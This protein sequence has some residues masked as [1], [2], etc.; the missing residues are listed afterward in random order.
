M[1]P[2]FGPARSYATLPTAAAAGMAIARG[3]ALIT[4]SAARYSQYVTTSRLRSRSGSAF[5]WR[6]RQLLAG[7]AAPV[8]MP[9]MLRDFCG[10]GPRLRPH[11]AGGKLPRRSRSGLLGPDE[12]LVVI[13]AD[14]VLDAIVGDVVVDLDRRALHEVRARRDQR[15]GQAA[16]EAQLCAADGIGDDNG[17]VGRVPDLELEL[18]VEGDVAVGG[19]LHADV[20]L[21]SVPEPRHV[22]RRADVHVVV[23]DLVVDHRCDRVRLADLLRLQALALEHVQ[24][25]GVAAEVQLV[26]AVDLHPAVHEEARQHAVGDR[27]ADLALDVV[28]NHRQ[29]GLGESALPVRLAADE[30][31]DGVD[32]GDARLDRL[33]GVP[34]GGLLAADRQVADHDVDLALLQDVHDVGGRAGRLLDDLGQ[35]LAQAVVG[36]AALDGNA[37]V[38]DIGELEGV[39]LAGED[40]VRQ[41][42]A[43]L[44]AIHVKGGDEL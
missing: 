16:I 8:L 12:R 27:G 41:V 13:A 26:G 20:A 44:L 7:C 31:R 15:A 21:L 30:D 2:R 29:A 40:R 23:G 42:L 14:E 35:V 36:H 6:P 28:T 37:A 10:R 4:L 17:A 9:S 32:E 22:V 11:V 39:V 19:A 25:V 1:S 33:L 24:E 3:T 43:H 18:H 34:L 5:A 38:R